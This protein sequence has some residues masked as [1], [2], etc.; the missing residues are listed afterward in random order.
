MMCTNVK[1]T[2]KN[3]TIYFGRTMDLNMSMFGED[4]G[5]DLEATIVSAPKGTLIESQLHPWT[6]KYDVMGVG[7]KGTAL[8]YDGINEF[9][10]TGDCQVLVET[11]RD[12]EEKII[13]KGK[14]PVLG[15]E[16][17][18]YVLTNFKDVAEI[19]AAYQDYM[20]VEQSIAY[21]NTTLQF[22]IHYTFIDETGDGIVLEPTSTNGFKLYEYIDVMTN[23]PKYDYHVTNIRQ[24]VGL[25]NKGV[26]EKVIN[27]NLVLKPIE[28]G[29]G[30]GILGIPG[31]YTS[32]S[33]FVRAFYYKNMIDDFEDSEGIN[34][35]YSVFR[36]LIIP[37]GLEHSLKGGVM[38][39]YTR[40]WSGYD[41]KKRT[42]YVQTGVGLAITAK[43]MDDTM[44]QVTYDAIQL[45]NNVYQVQ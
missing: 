16:F 40:Y 45:S 15:E 41:L 9:G 8:L 23:S 7:T 20:L 36:S 4:A 44:N 19:R 13:A 28:N 33:R 27:D 29:T 31:D 38:S 14:T 25:E 10:L 18:T 3:N 24:Y 26:A 17:V 42:L 37:R 2:S 21:Q 12:T 6:S 32:P 34:A 5:T 35:L 11:V 43:T 22:G 1:L 39:D 30:F